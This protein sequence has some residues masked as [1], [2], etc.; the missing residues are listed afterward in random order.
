MALS[1]DCKTRINVAL[2]STQAGTELSTTVNA[3]DVRVAI[4]VASETTSNASD[5]ATAITL[6][7]ALKVKLNAELTA[8]KNA[9]LQASS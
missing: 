9:G 7:N 4:N 2:A 1:E 8:L 5:L 3:I 6:V